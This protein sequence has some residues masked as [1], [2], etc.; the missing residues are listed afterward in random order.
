MTEQI[1]T[2][3]LDAFTEA[4]RGVVSLAPGEVL[5]WL[6]NGTESQHYQAAG[7]LFLADWTEADLCRIV[8]EKFSRGK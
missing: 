6:H 4:C 2:P 5:D 7:L 8:R 1:P 3:E